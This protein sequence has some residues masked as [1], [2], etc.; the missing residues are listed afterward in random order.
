MKKDYREEIKELKEE[1]IFLKEKCRLLEDK[2]EEILKENTILTEN[3]SKI[4]EELELYK[5]IFLV[6]NLE[7]KFMQ[8][9]ENFIKNRFPSI[10]NNILDEK[11]N[12]ILKTEKEKKAAN[13]SNNSNIEGSS[14]SKVFKVKEESLKKHTGD[15]TLTNF[16]SF[17]EKFGVIFFFI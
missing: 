1:N 7:I 5:S 3:L 8:K 9:K 11:K 12:I 4:N 13:N 17:Y 14:F 2:Q 15:L 16:L 6:K 10:Q